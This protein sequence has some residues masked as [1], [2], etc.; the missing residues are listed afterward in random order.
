[1]SLL[2]IELNVTRTAPFMA[3]RLETLIDIAF[4]QRAHYCLAI[5]WTQVRLVPIDRKLHFLFVSY[6]TKSPGCECSG[7]YCALFIVCRKQWSSDS[8]PTYLSTCSDSISR[9]L[10]YQASVNVNHQT[11][12]IIQWFIVASW[13]WITKHLTF[14]LRLW[15]Y[16]LLP[17][18]LLCSWSFLHTILSLLITSS[19]SSPSLASIVKAFSLSCLPKP[20]W[21]PHQWTLLPASSFLPSLQFPHN[22]IPNWIH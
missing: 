10:G 6:R 17:A 7:F 11:K 19:S 2:G 5:G 22:G 3:R 9:P 18:P 20:P 14:G 13:L 1:M 8:L 4:L 21:L 15:M 12:L 16:K